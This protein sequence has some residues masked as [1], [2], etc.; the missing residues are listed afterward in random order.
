MAVGRA[1]SKRQ[2]L[3][4]RAMVFVSCRPFAA[5]ILVKVE[6]A[7]VSFDNIATVFQA[8]ITCQWFMQLKVLFCTSAKEMHV[9]HTLEVCRLT[10]AVVTGFVMAAP[11]WRMGFDI[12]SWRMASVL[13]LPKR[14]GM[15]SPRMVDSRSA[16]TS[17]VSSVNL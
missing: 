3:P 16:Y 12:I 5:I 7:A 6:I 17:G 1:L 14:F 11:S 10:G 4:A 8:A 2:M 15:S 13:S 9:V